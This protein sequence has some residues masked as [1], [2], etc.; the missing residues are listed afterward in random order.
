MRKTAN[1]RTIKTTLA[2][3]GEAKLKKAISDV[4]KQYGLLN[5]EMRNTMA[6]FAKNEK[7][8]DSLTAKNNILGKQADAQKQK[9]S[10]LSE[11]VEKLNEK[12]GASDDRTVEWTK[13]LNYAEA[14]LK[15][16][17]RSISENCTEIEKLN[18]AMREEPVADLAGK[19]KIAETAASGFNKSLDRE[20]IDKWKDGFFE[21][22]SVIQGTF[23]KGTKAATVAAGALGTAT[24]AAVKAS[25]SQY[26]DFDDSVRNVVATMGLAGQEAKNTYDKL[27][28]AA[29][30]AG[31]STKFTA[32][33]SADAL[34]YLALA[35]YKA[36]QAISVLPSVLNLAQAG[37]MELAKASDLATD[38]MAALQ[39]EATKENLTLFGDRL[40]K[41]ASTANANITQ[42]GEGI[43]KVGASANVL[44][45]GTT[46][47]NTALGVLANRGTK[48]AEAGTVLRNVILALS[49]PTAKAKKELTTLG[50]SAL[51]ADGNMRPLNETFADFNRKMAAM[52][53][54]EKMA[55]LKNIFNRNDIADVQN[56]MD[57]VNKEWATLEAGIK[58]CDGAMSQ[59][60]QTLEGG[61][62]GSTRSLESSVESLKISVG[63]KFG[64]AAK[65]ITDTVTKEIDRVN[66]KIKNGD[67]DKLDKA[68]K[69]ITKS[70]NDFIKNTAP[71]LEKAFTFAVD[72]SGKI[73]ASFKGVAAGAVA[74]KVLSTAIALAT[75]KTQGL[76]AATAL[77]NF[78]K[79]FTNPIALGTVAVAGLT[80]ATVYA[81]EKI[82]AQ[83]AALAQANLEAHFGKIS[84]SLDEVN[85]AARRIADDGNFS[86][87]EEAVAGFAKTD[88]YI[89]GMENALAEIE[90]MNWKVSVG[91]ELTDDE[92]N[93]YKR[94]V[95][96]FINQANEALTQQRYSVSIA[97][98]VL[99]LEGSDTSKNIDKLFSGK[100]AQL[101]ELGKQLQEKVNASFEDGLLTIDEAN[102]ISDLHNQIS[103]ITEQMAGAEL[104]SKLDLI[105]LKFSGAELTPES[106]RELQEQVNEEI[107][108]AS[109]NYE[110]SFVEAS[111]A[112]RVELE[113]GEINQEEFDKSLSELQDGLN[114]KLSELQLKAADFGL[115]TVYDAFGEEVAQGIN[116]LFG[117]MDEEMSV[118]LQAWKDGDYGRICLDDLVN[119]DTELDETTK[120]NLA[121]L[122]EGLKPQEEQ[123]QQIAERYRAQGKLIPESIAQEILNIEAIGAISGNVDSLYTTIG[124]MAS[125]KNPEFLKAFEEE[126]ENLGFKVPEGIAEGAE[127]NRYALISKMEETASVSAKEFDDTST[128]LFIKSGGNIID[129]VIVGIKGNTWKLT[130]TL[131][132]LG[133]LA[134][135]AFKKG[136]QSNSPSKLF[137]KASE[138][139]PEGAAL[140]VLNKS[141]LL[142]EAITDMA[143]RGSAAF[144]PRFEEPS[145]DFEYFGMKAD[146]RAER[147][148]PPGAG[149]DYERL[150]RCM[151][152]ALCNVSI[153]CDKRQFGRLVS[154]VM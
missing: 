41:T 132:N 46:E 26:S 84:L 62:G 42:L 110:K 127:A 37:N 144:A 57:G 22:D 130:N 76:A 5:S 126:Y 50:V 10:A 88:E 118:Q 120:A 68:I 119:I 86:K 72:N 33:Q 137:A 7:S 49:A 11:I 40:A 66:E 58:N 106:Q 16:T 135:G 122:Y 151:V 54:S 93:A 73:V 60:A 24:A 103:R 56:L 87:L 51:D 116:N 61:L 1:D 75:G 147:E 81:T 39:L 3:D 2:I 123:L 138:A 12:Y 63:S 128:P 47:L 101:A 14:Q 105:K 99:G 44:K 117:K 59:M 134:K 143:E 97:L 77:L 64:D 65:S 154:E 96:E 23:I 89:N 18:R 35:G 15:T 34:N 4:G 8:V 70:T 82:K 71:K 153:E 83:K 113:D 146:L 74:Y 104:E 30:S 36:D 43:L 6:D 131:E 145:F 38:S 25:V 115:S 90:K 95:E 9:I 45:G 100:N 124:A 142:S 29:Q 67:S 133:P 79:S 152:A 140:G 111:A 102:V 27:Y 136:I 78:A 48:G 107:K 139:I 31:Q 149:I 19:F 69:S 148:N 98:N 28:A 91:M 20:K 21:A 17:Q 13:K 121:Q 55:S 52:S 85:D 109:E 125:E 114:A 108:K 94:T 80:A 32:G 150:A 141:H 129:G 112:L 53:D 92:K